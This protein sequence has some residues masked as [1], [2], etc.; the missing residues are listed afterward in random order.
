ML[1]PRK[2]PITSLL[3]N[4]RF[5][6]AVF[7]LFLLNIVFLFIIPVTADE[8]YY[9]LWAHHPALSYFDH[10]P[11]VAYLLYISTHLF[12]ENA[13][14]IRFFPLIFSVFIPFVWLEIF[15]IP[16]DL[17]FYVILVLSPILQVSLFFMTPDVPLLLFGSLFLLIHNKRRDDLLAAVF[18]GLSLLS[19]YTAVIFYI[20][21]F[22][23]IM[24]RKLSIYK[25]F[26][27][28][29]LIPFL[30]FSPVLYF[31]MTHNWVSFKYQLAH[32][33]AG[34]HLHFLFFLK[35]I[36]DIIAVAGLPLSVY[37]FFN[38]KGVKKEHGFVFASGMAYLIFF[39]FFSFFSRQEAN[40]PLFFY[41][42]ILFTGYA[43]LDRMQKKEISLI[44][45]FALA[46]PLKPLLSFTSLREKI[47]KKEIIIGEIADSIRN[48]S[49]PV[50][51]NTYQHASLLSYYL[52]KDVMA[53]NIA[54]RPNQFDLWRYEIPRTEFLFVGILYPEIKERFKIDSTLFLMDNIGVYMVR[55]IK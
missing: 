19:K 13:F 18:L 26:L 1:L 38:L 25:F 42:L 27:Y 52:K 33:G 9:L 30:L 36:V 32:G 14:G 24:K 39:A 46:L 7:L 20:P 43:L 41:P 54:S 12:G 23:D 5:F 48:S 11:L 28:Y 55:E 6:L 53:L 29:V 3:Q 31:N 8:A 16:Y 15:E 44:V 34:F 47:F 21:L 45:F 17:W 40:W 50:F 37:G 22:M 4:K 49:M 2:H 35:Y 51:A 10:P